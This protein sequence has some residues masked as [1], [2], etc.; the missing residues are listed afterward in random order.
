MKTSIRS[1]FTAALTLTALAGTA[2]ARSQGAIAGRAANP[3]DAACFVESLGGVRNACATARTYVMPIVYD[4]AGDRT[5][6]VFA[7]GVAGTARRVS[8]RAVTVDRAQGAFRSGALVSSV[9]HTGATEELN[10]TVNCHGWGACWA[11]CTLDP[12]TLV[13][14]LHW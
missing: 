1:L 4:D 5:L 13:H 2:Q 11:I 9:L 14:S 3:A 10:S 6:H 7:R 8:C 12:N